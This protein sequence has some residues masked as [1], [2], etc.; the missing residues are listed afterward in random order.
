MIVN[1]IGLSIGLE[2][3]ILLTFAV[4]QWFQVPV[5]NWIDWLIG[6]V[7]LWWLLVI[8]TVPWNLHFQARE[9]LAD[10]ATSGE[11]G[12]PVDQ[13]QVSYV[14]R[15]AQRSLWIAV[16]LHLISALVLYGLAVTGV[17]A[18]GYAG[19]GA[20]L[21]LTVLRPVVRAYE[22]LVSRLRN[23]GQSL[24]YPREDIV[25][26]RQ[27]FIELETKVSQ[28]SDHIN[29]EL[30]YSWAAT[31][32]NSWEELRRETARLNASLEALRATNQ[33][34]HQR[35]ARDAQSAIAQLSTDGQ[36]LDHVREII[37]FFKTA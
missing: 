30:Q 11:K 28:L 13:Q 8:T 3:F 19:S 16:A 23:I 36:F 22:Y 27:R 10:A 26:L 5:G 6:G 33:S 12:I 21:L 1:F 24:L 4:L 18:V 9:V 34:D 25:E 32:H 15:L 2:L 29:P 20:A 14:G 7:S 17:T 37:R 35:L 31:Q